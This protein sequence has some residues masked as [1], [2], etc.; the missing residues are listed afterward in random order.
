MKEL[1]GDGVGE[2][3]LHKAVKVAAAACWGWR[4]GEYSKHEG[5]RGQNYLKKP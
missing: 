4:E 3:Q 2:G 1:T 5:S